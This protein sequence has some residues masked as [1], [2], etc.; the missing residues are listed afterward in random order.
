MQYI[1]PPINRSEVLQHAQAAITW[2][3]GDH[4]HLMPFPELTDPPSEP[5]TMADALA[6]P[7]QFQQALPPQ[8]EAGQQISLP[9]SA[10]SGNAQL[11]GSWGVPRSVVT[12]GALAGLGSSNTV[13][14]AQSA[15]RA[16]T[17]VG[18]LLGSGPNVLN[19]GVQRRNP[20]VTDPRIRGSRVGSHARH[21][22][23]NYLAGL[24]IA[25]IE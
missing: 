1:P 8:I 3:K 15:V 22:G 10:Q 14:G 21:G 6:S 4:R 2:K 20:I 25:R 7:V 24:S 19:L 16:T 23:L 12:S 9:A 5:A 13:S 18:D 17:D 11:F